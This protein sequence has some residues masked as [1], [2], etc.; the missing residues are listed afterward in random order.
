MYEYIKGKYTF[1]N[2]DYIVIENNGIGYKI[3]T[4][5]NT[6]KNLPEL[7]KDTMLYTV[8]LVRQDFMGLYGF[9][10]SEELQLFQTLITINGVG[11]K[12]ALSLLSLSGPDKLKKLIYEE[13]LNAITKA[14]GIGPKTAKRI[15]LELKD[16]ITV[17]QD[18]N[19]GTDI[20]NNEIK[21]ALT[22]LG[23]SEKEAASAVLKVDKTLSIESSIKE[24][25]KIL[26]K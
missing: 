21:Q 5:G 12:A 16:K 26:M 17:N 24:C 22:S 7:N 4:S 2:K 23:Y 25:L 18:N 10:T 1:M 13:N 3:F 11:S 9:L 6:I 14:P 19:E 15:I 20:K 8:L